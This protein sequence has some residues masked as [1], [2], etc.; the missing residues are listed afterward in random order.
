MK[1]GSR[2]VEWC[3]YDPCDGQST[4]FADFMTDKEGNRHNV[5]VPAKLLRDDAWAAQIS[6][7]DGTLTP[8]WRTIFLKSKAP[9]L[10]AVRS[11]HNDKSSFF[12]GKLF[13]AGEA[14]TQIRP[15]LGASC[16]IP[17]LQ[18]LSLAK[19]LKSEMSVAEY[20]KEVAA[21]ALGK[22]IGSKATGDFGLTGK[23]PE[24]YTPNSESYK[25]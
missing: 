4:E 16:D 12:S 2:L 17:A 7:R 10:T 19:V 18:A 14:Y 11:F 6:R 5:T 24:G 21:Y 22:A 3:W 23:W 25:L 13:L 20:E 9:L 8:L 15:H 1:V